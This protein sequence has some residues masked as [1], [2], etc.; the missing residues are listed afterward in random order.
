ML[1]QLAELL[2]SKQEFLALDISVRYGKKTC[3]KLLSELL[4]FVYSTP[5]PPPQQ[6]QGMHNKHPDIRAN[7]VLA[8]LAM[9]GDL[10][11]GLATKVWTVF[12]DSSDCMHVCY[13]VLVLYYMKLLGFKNVQ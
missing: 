10:N 1:E 12:T 4:V 13:D 5:P 3:T 11:K 2:N 6:T 8:V 9:R 7:H